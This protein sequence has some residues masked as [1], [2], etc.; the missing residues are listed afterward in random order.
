MRTQVQKLKQD[1]QV[2][3]QN[4]RNIGIAAHIDAGKTTLSE[5]FLFYTGRIHKMGEVHAKGTPAATMDSG[6]IEIDMGIT[7]SSAATRCQWGEYAINLIDTPGHV[8]FTI[9][10]ERS[11]R[12]LDG[13]VMALCAVGGVQSQTLT[14]D[15][16]IRRYQLPRIA[17][18][19]KMDRAGANPGRVVDELRQR[20][21]LNAHTLQAPL[22]EGGDIV[23][24]LDLVRRRAIYF[25]GEFGQ[26]LRDVEVP[27]ENREF[28]LARRQELFEALAEV[29]EEIARIFLEERDATATELEAAIRRAT[30]ALRFTPVLL[31]S[32]Y[33]NVGV[34]PLLDAVCA[35]LPTPDER[36][37]RAFD[38]DQNEAEVELVS[39][40][41][42]P[43][44]MLA[45][46]TRQTPQGLLVYG[47]IYQGRVKAGEQIWNV[48]RARES[49]VSRIVR[50]HADKME[51]LEWAQAGDVVAFPGLDC[52]S[53]D[54]FTGDKARLTLASMF[55]PEPVVS[56]AVESE[57][58]DSY[59]ALAK[60]LEK[61]CREDPTFRF[62]MDS[63]TGGLVISGMGELHLEIYLRRMADEFGLQ[64]RTGPPGVA[65][66]ETPSVRAQ[67]DYLLKKQDGGQG[68]YAR[69][70][71]YME[72][73]NSSD[74]EFAEGDDNATNSDFEFLDLTTGGCI[75][76]EFMKGVRA[77]FEGLLDAGTLRGS[78]VIGLRVVIT[79]GE[80][81]SKDSSEMA[82]RHCAEIV[83]RETFGRTAPVILEPIMRVDIEGPEEFLGSI[84]ALV[85]RRRGLI[86]MSQSDGARC[87][88]EALAPLAE[89]FGFAGVLRSATRGQAD[90]GME[91]QK[92]E[93]GPA[94]RLK[95]SNT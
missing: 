15:R 9:E 4:L 73:V 56:L 36:L 31:G 34:Q 80:T 92:Y 89:L 29:D 30:L 71:G 32:A 20:L 63:E 79:D 88:I 6:K 84:T 49:R 74:D 47:R 18:I 8:D 61:F 78:P 33:K 60:A 7:I 82:F 46:K 1:K 24:V 75:P 81:H 23:G 67:F 12:V 59:K 39:D 68:Q 2:S 41:D 87:R 50:M 55:V 48:N 25:D 16:Q 38:Q 95:A 10:V 77:G 26:V 14:V 28:V 13:A 44:V 37:N 11:L 27:P 22:F 21:G 93:R 69:I 45:F 35:Y 53:G 91:F 40:P 94:E 90:F 17:F 52:A 66:R 86:R 3:S 83:F 85:N 43:L 57:G 51:A 62:R 76:R 72:P 42:L 58:R 70:V 54:S 64:V 19:N 65:Y 5:R